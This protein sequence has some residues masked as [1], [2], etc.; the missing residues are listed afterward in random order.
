MRWWIAGIE[1]TAVHYAELFLGV[2]ESWQSAALK[3]RSSLEMAQMGA[4]QNS[5]LP[6]SVQTGAALSRYVRLVPSLKM[7]VEMQ[8]E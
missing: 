6:E 2:I 3:R 5:L 8:V 7:A 4:I 1:N